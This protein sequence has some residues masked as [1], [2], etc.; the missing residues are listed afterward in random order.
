MHGRSSIWGRR[1]ATKQ[2]ACS[3]G[4]IVTGH[5][6][7]RAWSLAFN[8]FESWREANCLECDN[9]KHMED[10]GGNACQCFDQ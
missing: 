2:L 9:N 3:R 7:E 1:S 5:A 8:C 6:M 4:A 10:C